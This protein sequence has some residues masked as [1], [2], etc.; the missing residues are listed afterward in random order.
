MELTVKQ[1]IEELNKLPRDLKVQIN[2]LE[3][4]HRDINE[5]QIENQMVYL[6]PEK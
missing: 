2:Y 4:F 6:I 5:I 1:L 3:D